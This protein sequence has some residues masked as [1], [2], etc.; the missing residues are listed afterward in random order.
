MSIS[1]AAR[2]IRIAIS[3]R[4]A[5]RIFRIGRQP[6]RTGG[7]VSRTV[8]I[9]R[10]SGA[11]RMRRP[12]EDN[13]VPERDLVPVV[14]FVHRRRSDSSTRSIRSFVNRDD[15][16]WELIRVAVFK[17]SGVVGIHTYKDKD[18]ARSYGFIR[19][20]LI[21]PRHPSAHQRATATEKSRAE[22]KPGPCAQ[23]FEAGS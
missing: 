1:V 10:V 9:R 5:A 4:F 22:V 6:G 3:P 21:H 17:T 18:I 11:P 20:S 23:L 13:I 15:G 2:Q 19:S 16:A 14:R 7:G 8:D 12:S